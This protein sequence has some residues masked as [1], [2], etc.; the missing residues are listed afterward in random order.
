MRTKEAAMVVAEQAPRTTSRRRWR[1][2]DCRAWAKPP[3]RTRASAPRGRPY[4][5]PPPLPLVLLPSPWR[6]VHTV[7]VR[8]PRWGCP[9]APSDAVA[10]VGAV[11]R[12]KTVVYV[13]GLPTDANTEEELAAFFS[14]RCGILKIDF[15]TSTATCTRRWRRVP[16]ARTHP[17]GGGVRWRDARQAQGEVVPHVRRLS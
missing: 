4:R 10:Q 12:P 3:K 7:T 13:T 8:V 17:R 1:L 5:P 2:H 9:H 11:S 16:V 6:C 14:K 15:E